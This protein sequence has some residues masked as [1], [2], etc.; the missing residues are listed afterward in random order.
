MPDVR[1]RKRCL[2]DLQVAQQKH[3]K[4][5]T[6]TRKCTGGQVSKERQLGGEERKQNKKLNRQME[7]EDQKKK[8]KKKSLGIIGEKEESKNNSD[9]WPISISRIMN[10]RSCKLV[11]SRIRQVIAQS[12]GISIKV[13][14][15]DQYARGA[16]FIF[17]MTPVNSL[18]SYS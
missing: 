18:D 2:R 7:A 14:A 15:G 6:I 12:V 9:K 5:D 8:V 13:L 17:Y 11:Q 16:R 10:H 4:G 3:R 1:K